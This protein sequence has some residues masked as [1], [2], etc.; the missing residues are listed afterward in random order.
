MET[1]LKVLL[2]SPDAMTKGDFVRFA[3]ILQGVFETMHRHT[4]LLAFVAVGLIVC[5]VLQQRQIRKINRRLD[6]LPV[7]KEKEK[8]ELRAKLAELD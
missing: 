5:V 2:E 8:A 4:L 1:L 7:D 6:D 3:Q